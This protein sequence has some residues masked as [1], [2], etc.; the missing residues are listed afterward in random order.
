MSLVN[1]HQQFNEIPVDVRK[2]KCG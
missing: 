1:T 2:G